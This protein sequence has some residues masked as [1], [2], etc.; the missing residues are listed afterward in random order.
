LQ[1]KETFD[2]FVAGTDLK[3]SLMTGNRKK[4]AEKELLQAAE[5]S[6]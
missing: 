6:K 1:I 2:L 4:D 5:G 3:V